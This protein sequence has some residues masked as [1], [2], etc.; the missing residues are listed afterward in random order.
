MLGDAN[1]SRDAPRDT[2]RPASFE[3][4]SRGSS[5]AGSGDDVKSV[6]LSR[7]GLVDTYA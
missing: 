7:V 4:A 5:D 2:F 1:V 3:N 6:T